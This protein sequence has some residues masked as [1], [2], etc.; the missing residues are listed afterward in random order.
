ML[1]IIKFFF[2]PKDVTKPFL[3]RTTNVM[4]GST[5]ST[6]TEPA[7]HA[8]VLALYWHFILFLAYWIPSANTLFRI[9]VFI[10]FIS[11]N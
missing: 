5:K 2:S 6:N 10:N 4:N 1:S 11:K 8:C 3:C 9:F 7:L